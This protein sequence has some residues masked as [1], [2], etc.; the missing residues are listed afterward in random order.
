MS[1]KIHRV[2]K[3]VLFSCAIG[4]GLISL[5]MTKTFISEAAFVPLPALIIYLSVTAYAFYI[6]FRKY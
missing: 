5:I 3:R 2:V 6:A 1:S 4:F